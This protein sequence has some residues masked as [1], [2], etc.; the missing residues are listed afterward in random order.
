MRS[1]PCCSRVSRTPNVKTGTGVLPASSAHR[2]AAPSS[3]RAALTGKGNPAASLGGP[4]TE[5]GRPG[6]S[7]PQVCQRHSSSTWANRPGTG[8]PKQEALGLWA[9][10]GALCRAPQGVGQTHRVAARSTRGHRPRVTARRLPQRGRSARAQ[11]WPAA[12]KA[13]PRANPTVGPTAQPT[14]CKTV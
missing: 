10:V 13:G 3:G 4:R 6:P 5:A 2:Q 7:L 9:C 1:S 8:R 12:S 14:V 11:Q